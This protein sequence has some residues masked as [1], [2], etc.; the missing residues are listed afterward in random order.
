MTEKKLE[1]YHVDDKVERQRRHCTQRK[2]KF[3]PHYGDHRG[4]YHA[5]IY[6]IWHPMANHAKYQPT[7]YYVVLYDYVSQLDNY[8]KTT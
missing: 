3:H 7:S 5:A 4:R 2:R 8:R 1:T 6:T